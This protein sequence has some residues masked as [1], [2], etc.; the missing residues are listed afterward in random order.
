[1]QPIAV[2]V[3]TPDVVVGQRD[4]PLLDAAA[5]NCCFANVYAFGNGLGVREI[6]GC[7]GVARGTGSCEG[8]LYKFE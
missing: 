5:A 2:V 1:M 7:L 6:L 4:F 3:A 8:E